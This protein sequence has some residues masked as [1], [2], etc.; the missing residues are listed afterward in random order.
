MADLQRKAGV[1]DKHLILTEKR[2]RSTRENAAYGAVILRQHG[3]KRI[4]LV[5][6]AQSMPRAS[7]CF[8]KE[9]IE[10]TAAPE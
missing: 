8:R 4:V 10:V 2:S 7:A 9:G 6:E 3:I 5:V 1:P